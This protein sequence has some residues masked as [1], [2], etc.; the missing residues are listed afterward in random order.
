VVQ[1]TGHDGGGARMACSRI[2]LRRM[3]IAWPQCLQ[4]KVGGAA[5]DRPSAC[6][7]LLGVTACVGAALN[8]WRVS[9]RH[10]PRL[11]LASKP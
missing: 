1:V 5:L 9:A 3:A 8:N 10:S 4:T 6:S 7:S 11:P 2:R